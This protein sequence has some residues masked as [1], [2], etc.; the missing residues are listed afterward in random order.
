MKNTDWINYIHCPPQATLN[1]KNIN[2]Y[3][4]NKFKLIKS[5]SVCIK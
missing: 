5:I 1:I 2:V 3:L 4:L